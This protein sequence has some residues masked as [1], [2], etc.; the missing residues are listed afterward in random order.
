MKV[1]ESPDYI[2]YDDLA[3][4]NMI[5]KGS[6]REYTNESLNEISSGAIRR[7]DDCMTNVPTQKRLNTD[8]NW[9]NQSS[10]ISKRRKSNSDILRSFAK[11]FLGTLNRNQPIQSSSNKSTKNQSSGV[12]NSVGM[13]S[14]PIKDVNTL[15]SIPNAITNRSNVLSIQAMSYD[16]EHRN[17]PDLEPESTPEPEKTPE[18][19][20]TFENI[21]EIDNLSDFSYVGPPSPDPTPNN[22][23]MQKQSNADANLEST[24]PTL[25]CLGCEESLFGKDVCSLY[26]GHIYCK[27]CI[28]Y[29]IAHRK[30]CLSCNKRVVKKHWFDIYFTHEDKLKSSSGGKM[31]RNSGW[32]VNPS[33]VFDERPQAQIK[34]TDCTTTLL[35]KGT[36]T[37]ALIRCG[38]LYC[39]ACTEYST[40]NR[41]PCI[42]CNKRSNKN[43][44]IEIF[45]LDQN[46]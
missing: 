22:T 39:A 11:K 12:I 40:S 38:H 29:D 35:K 42:K 36:K 24:A 3:I 37:F 5:L 8:E 15:I 28:E 21:P 14:E 6:P 32:V 17:S 20:D 43:E 9:Q 33:S 34:C 27:D 25:K 44:R 2:Q 18:P 23:P 10:A 4:R 46:W 7:L 26:C 19:D 41:K 1:K 30:V 16:V 13:K 45:L 31:A